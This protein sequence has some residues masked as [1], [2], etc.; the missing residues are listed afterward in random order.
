MNRKGQLRPPAVDGIQTFDNDGKATK[1][2]S[3]S[4]NVSK[5][6]HHQKFE[7][8]QQ[9]EALAAPFNF[10]SFSAWPLLVLGCYFLHPGCFWLGCMYN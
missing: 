3:L 8:H 10:T 2:C 1:H 7:F 5:T 9:Q 6:G 4:L